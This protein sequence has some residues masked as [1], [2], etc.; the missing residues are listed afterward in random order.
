MTTLARSTPGP[1]LSARALDVRVDDTNL[2]V[3]LEDGRGVSVPVAW[4]P[5]LAQATQEQRRNWR[6]IGGGVGIHWPDLDEDVSVENLLGA[7]GDLLMYQD[8][9]TA[10]SVALSSAEEEEAAA[11]AASRRSRISARRT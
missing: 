8:S 5:R 6:L 4:F 9:A 1:K 2:Y 11:R 7:D 10:P 3:A